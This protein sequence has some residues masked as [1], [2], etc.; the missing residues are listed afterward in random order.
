VIFVEFPNAKV[1]V[2]VP[3]KQTN[4]PEGK[5]MDAGFALLFR[6]TTSGPAVQLPHCPKASPSPARLKIKKT[7]IRK[8]GDCINW[9]FSVVWRCNLVT[10]IG[11]DTFFGRKKLRKHKKG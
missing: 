4:V 11:A 2:L 10:T 7:K 3:V 6:I 9:Y 5:G 8:R 1:V